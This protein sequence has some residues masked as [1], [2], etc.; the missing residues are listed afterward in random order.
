MS[1]VSLLDTVLICAR[2]GRAGFAPEI[3][4]AIYSSYGNL[5]IPLYNLVPS[6]LS[7]LTLAL[8]PLL[9]A[10]FAADDRA[11][12]QGALS[13]AL[14]L[15]SLF[16]MPAALGLAVFARPILS[17]IYVGQSAAIDV[18]APLLSILALSEVPAGLIT[19]AGAALQ[20]M[21]HT[22]VP[23]LAMG[24]GAIV[25]LV[26][27][28]ALLAIPCVHIYG[29]PVSTLACNLTVL[30]VEAVALG[31]ILPF[32]V[33]IA[34]DLLRPFLAAIC[35]VGAGAGLYLLLLRTCGEAIWQMPTVLLF[36]LLLFGILALRARAIEHDNLL[37]VPHGEKL[38]HILEKWKLIKR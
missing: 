36:V 8:M 17:L 5:A 21:G 7:P 32:R 4:N 11:G 9:G 14:R 19:L 35:S 13:S 34:R 29:A 15:T 24:A 23:V 12:A 3:A 6:L 28:V 10:C 38:C 18:A 37:A 26:V 33:R 27:E 22:L 25:K 31:R 16:S 2:L 20:A 1:L 30:I